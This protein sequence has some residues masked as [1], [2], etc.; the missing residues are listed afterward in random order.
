MGLPVSELCL[1]CVQPDDEESR[2]EQEADEGGVSFMAH[3]PVPS[4]KEVRT[5]LLSVGSC[6]KH[7]DLPL[8]QVEEALVRRKKMEL[9]QRYASEALQAQ[10]QTAKTLLGL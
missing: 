5:L 6:G 7:P 8:C 9:L 10:S 2:C 1:L 3:V 4:Q